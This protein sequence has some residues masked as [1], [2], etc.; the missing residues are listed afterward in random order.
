MY[1]E[2]KQPSTI[3]TKMKNQEEKNLN[4]NKRTARFKEYLWFIG[5]WLLGFIVTL[6]ISYMIKIIMNF[7]YK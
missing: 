2:E 4:S 5:L 1:L 3:F 6:S 7:L